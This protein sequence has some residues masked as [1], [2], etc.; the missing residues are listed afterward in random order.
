MHRSVGYSL[1]VVA[2]LCL[3]TPVAIFLANDWV[4]TAS[5]LHPKPTRE[6]GVSCLVLGGIAVVL[7]VTVSFENDFR[8]WLPLLCGLL[9]L[10]VL[11]LGVW[12]V[13]DLGGDVDCGAPLPGAASGVS[14]DEEGHSPEWQVALFTKSHG[15]GRVAG[16]GFEPT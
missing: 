11:A 8:P 7:A 6:F 16:V 3:L 15:V 13:A 4:L 10:G 14:G 5:C 9:A 1:L 12:V 2:L